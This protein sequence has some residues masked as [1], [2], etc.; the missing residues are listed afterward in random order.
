MK[1]IHKHSMRLLLVSLFLVFST[2]LRATTWT[3]SLGSNVNYS[4]DSQ[5]R[6]LTISG[7]GAMDNYDLEYVGYYNG[8][9]SN[10]PLFDRRWYINKIIIEEGVTTVGNNAFY[11]CSDLKH[12][13]LPNGLTSIGAGAF[14]ICM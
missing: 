2:V 12:V 11:A 13:S 1:Y 9:N 6:V 14:F 10:S 7:S 8:Y 3:G 5:T 4:L